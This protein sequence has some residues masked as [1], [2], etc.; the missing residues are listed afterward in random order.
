MRRIAMLTALVAVTTFTVVAGGSGETMIETGEAAHDRL[1]IRVTPGEHYLHDLKVAWWLTVTNG[2]QMAVWMEDSDGKYLQT[3][4]VTE[5]AA[6]R[7][8]RSAPL[9]GVD[10]EDIRRQEAL[11]VWQHRV[12]IGD[13]D[14]ATARDERTKG[15]AA[16]LDAVTGA[17]SKKDLTVNAAVTLPDEPFRVMLEVNSSTDFNDS[18]P[19]DAEPGDS[20]YS[21]GPWGSGQPALV[22][23]AD[24][25]PAELDEPVRLRLL[26]HSSPD[27]DDGA[28]HSGTEGITTAL[29]IL[30]RVTIEGVSQR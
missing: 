21:G 14:G 12:G 25:D 7:S 1:T 30:D 10:S 20:G 19:R 2:P 5:R 22:Y 4:Y 16:G 28:V 29:E 17:T 15:R 27:G 11:P 3:L 6:E 24:I 13:R 8:W 9:E 26:G 23:G 18:F